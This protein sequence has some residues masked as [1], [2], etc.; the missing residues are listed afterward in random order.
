MEDSSN[1]HWRKRYRVLPR[2]EQRSAGSRW[3]YRIDHYSSLPVVALAVGLL[4]VGAVVIGI[5]AGFPKNWVVAFE[6]GTS[7]VT[8][9]MVFVIQHTQGRE[10]AATQRKLDELLRALPEATTGLMMLE[11]ASEE[12]MRR[13]EEG[14]RAHK[15]HNVN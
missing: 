7:G 5:V 11:E 3:L 15:R 10:Q 12:D 6:A 4:L 2:T 13:V 14:Q 9:A 1:S 8:L